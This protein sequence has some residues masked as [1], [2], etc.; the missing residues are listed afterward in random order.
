M[1]KGEVVRLRE[2]NR[3]QLELRP[4]D[5]D[6]VL[7]AEHSARAI[8]RLV[9]SLKLEGFYSAIKAV[10]GSPGQNATDPKILL[11][12]W[13]YA[14]SEGYSSAREVA[15]LTQSHDA[16]RWIC[17]GVTVNYHLLSDFRVDHELALDQLMSEV[18]AVLMERNLISLH[19]VAQDGTRVRAS[20]GAASFRRKAR[21]KA[22][23]KTARA[24]IERLKSEPQSSE[25]T[26]RSQA[27]QQ[28]AAVERE[29]RLTQALGEL[30]KLNATRAQAKNHAQREVAARASSTDPEARVMKM[31]NGGFNPAYNVQLATDTESRLIVGVR[32]SNSGSDSRQLEPMLDEIERRTGGLPDQHLADGGFLH[33]QTV[34][35]AAERGVEVFAPLRE[36]ANYVNPHK[37]QPRDSQAIAQFRQRMSSPAG[38]KIYQERAATAETVN[39]DL[40][41]NR[42]LDRLLVRGMTKV[43]MVAMWSALTYNLMRAIR[44]GWL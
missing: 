18:L 24:H 32:V 14:T 13:L 8:W 25:T 16:Y 33:F 44:M 23:L 10:A 36:H 37:V 2:A 35:H 5:L 22:C 30:E 38:K 27:A 17:G 28:R 6:S 43:L 40:K 34:E 4:Y 41:T 9:E 31:P 20:A 15:R 42:G 1:E 21:L 3:E 39:A 11:A 7:G 19:R 12:L 26:L 29:R